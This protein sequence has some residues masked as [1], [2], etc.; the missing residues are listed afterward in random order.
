MTR[1][2][3]D[4]LLPFPSSNDLNS[5]V[6]IVLYQLLY[7]YICVQSPVQFLLGIAISTLSFSCVVDLCLVSNFL[8]QKC[9]AFRYFMHFLVL[10]LYLLVG[11]RIIFTFKNWKYI[12]KFTYLPGKKVFWK[13]SGSTHN[14]S[15]HEIENWT[16]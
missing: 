2:L 11:D 16:I 13:T 14:S 5:C 9:W 3:S 4:I 12:P 8:Y 6:A 15:Y 10:C 7:I 1:F